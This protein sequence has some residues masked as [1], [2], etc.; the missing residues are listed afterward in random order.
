MVP[1]FSLHLLQALFLV[2]SGMTVFSRW[3]MLLSSTWARFPLSVPS[4][5]VAIRW[6]FFGVVCC[7]VTRFILLLNTPPFF[8]FPENNF[9]F[10]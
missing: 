6:L 9:F 2:V 8:P 7:G 3:R 1:F 4:Q 5:F 10:L